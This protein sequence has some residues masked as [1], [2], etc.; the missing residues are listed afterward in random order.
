LL[1]RIGRREPDATMP[2]NTLFTPGLTAARHGRYTRRGQRHRSGG[3]RR[4]SSPMAPLNT[5]HTGY[6]E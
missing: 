4:P 1:H 2:R 5:S 6:R 3:V